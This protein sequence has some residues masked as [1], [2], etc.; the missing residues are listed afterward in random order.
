MFGILLVTAIGVVI[1]GVYWKPKL[2]VIR[3]L[4]NL[5]T[6]R[7][8]AFGDKESG[9]VVG[10]LVYLGEALISPL[11]GRECAYYDIRV[12]EFNN[13]S[14]HT[15]IRESAGVEFEVHDGSG[16]AIVEPMEALTAITVDSHTTSGSFDDPTKE[17]EV[18]L[19]RHQSEGRGR[20]FNKSLRYH[21]GVFEQ[22][23][24]VAVWGRGV[25]E[26]DSR[27]PDTGD[28]GYR[29]APTTRLR[30]QRSQKELLRISD[31]TRTT[32]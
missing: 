22:G 29:D 12:Q 32:L 18:F 30:M 6:K 24:L 10:E 26:Y 16:I 25:K 1:A 31:D 7:I 9:K 11:S 13:K 20:M 8:A 17:E 5:E 14:W 28:R 3:E 27:P 19:A 2:R 21:E 4:Q 23:E 15:I